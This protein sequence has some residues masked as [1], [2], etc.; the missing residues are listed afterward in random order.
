VIVREATLFDLPAG[1]VLTRRHLDVGTAVVLVDEAV[2]VDGQRYGRLEENVWVKSDALATFKGL[3]ETTDAAFQATMGALAPGVEVDPR[4]QPALWVLHREI[5]FRYLADTIADQKVPIRVAT[6]GA[7]EIAGYSFVDRT[8]TMPERFVDAD[9]RALAATLAHEATHAWEHTQGLLPPVGANCFEAE[10]RAFRN[11]AALWERF[12]GAGGKEKPSNELEAE[13]NDVMRL[14]K[15]DPEGLKARLINA[16]GDQCAYLGRRPTIVPRPTGTAGATTPRPGGTVA[17]GK[18]G[19][20]T[21]TGTVRS[22]ATT[23]ASVAP[24][25]PGSSPPK[26]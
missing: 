9:A 5:D 7:G 15:E 17:P 16:Y 4:V 11:Q 12:Y 20:P 19:A 1:D 18:P 21:A 6:L 8:I 13:H 26:P 22:A 24:G 3:D 23:A 25:K 2:G 10:L 14:L